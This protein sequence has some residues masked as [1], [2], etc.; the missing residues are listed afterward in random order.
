MCFVFSRNP[1]PEKDALLND[2]E[3]PKF[4]SEIMSYVDINVALQ[5]FENPRHYR[6]VSSVLNKYIEPPLW[7]Y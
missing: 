2:L 7:V 4:T 6:E 5:I 1:T 3:W